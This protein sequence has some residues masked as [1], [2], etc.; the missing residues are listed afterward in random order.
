MPTKLRTGQTLLFIGDSIT[1]CGRRGTDAPLGAGYVRIFAD[2]L[3]LREPAK[4]VTIVNKG[5]GG[6]TVEDLQA[7]WHDDV[8]RLE[9]DWL[10]IKIGINDLH[11]TLFQGPNPVPPDQFREI[12]DEILSRT[13][14]IL[15]GRRILLIDP[16]YISINRNG[17]SPRAAVLEMLPRYLAVVHEMSRRYGARL[18]RTHEMFQRLL[19]HHDPDLFCPEPVHPNPT[20]HLAIAEAVYEALSG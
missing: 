10:S 17:R 19:K 9:P 15:P 1:D 8:L 14:T 16:F 18:V 13:A 11:R 12:Y 5:I 6:N 7:R 4:R 3:A 20:G 2:L